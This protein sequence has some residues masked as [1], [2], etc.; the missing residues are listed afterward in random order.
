M[1]KWKGTCIVM[2][3]QGE[4]ER[5]ERK[6]GGRDGEREEREREGGEEEREGERSA[7]ELHYQH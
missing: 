6:G 4:R 2:R 1:Q 3:Y 7:H 5:E